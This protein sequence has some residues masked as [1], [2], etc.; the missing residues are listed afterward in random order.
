MI[1]LKNFNKLLVA[2]LA[3][4][5]FSSSSS[6]AEKAYSF[7]I[8]PQQSATKMVRLWGPVLARISEESGIK[9][10]FKTA[11]DIPTFEGEVLNGAYDFSYMNPYHYLIFSQ[12]PKHEAFAKAKNKR[13]QGIIVV[14]KDSSIMSLE[15]LHEQEVAFPSPAAFA[16][17]LL[18]YAHMCE[19]EIFYRPSYVK[20]HDSVS[21]PE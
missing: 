10:K 6:W 18:P 20:S 11:K 4:T 12:H 5:I 7:G 19:E 21:T 8:V 17:T 9:L 15:E 3:I 13:I 1:K 16:A 14:R 2:T